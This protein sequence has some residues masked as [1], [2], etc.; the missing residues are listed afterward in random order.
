MKRWSPD[1]SMSSAPKICGSS[2]GCHIALATRR[3]P[4]KRSDRMP[5]LPAL[6]AP[7]GRLVAVRTVVAIRAMITY[8]R[9]LDAMQRHRAAMRHVARGPVVPVANMVDPDDPR[10]RRGD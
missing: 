7:S 10:G 5:E 6:L 4:V 8:D 2:G 1:A 9:A 3:Q